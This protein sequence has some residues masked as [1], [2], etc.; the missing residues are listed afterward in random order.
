MDIRKALVVAQQHIVFRLELLDEVLFQQQRLGFGLRR[1]HHHG[2]GFRNHL[3]D[4]RRMARGLGIIANTPVQV[5]RLAH[6]Q[7]RALG[8]EHP[9]HARR[10]VNLPVERPDIGMARH[11]RGVWF[12]RCRLGHQ[13]LRVIL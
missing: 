1:Q 10:L 6:I 13:R 8:I 9:I 5:A 4:A 7:H 11:G 3:G 2:A 12:G